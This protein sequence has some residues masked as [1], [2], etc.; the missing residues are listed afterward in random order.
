[1]FF[2]KERMVNMRQYFNNKYN[3]YVYEIFSGGY[4]AT[5]K[6]KV[7][8]TTLLGSCVSACLMDEK[9][10]VAGMN[11]FLLPG[12][13]RREDM[14]ASPSAKY[15]MH[16]MEMLIN[17]MMK[18]GARRNNLKA[19]IFGGGHI[20][21]ASN[22]AVSENNVSFIKAY[23]AMEE[24]PVLA[25]DLGGT[26]GRKILLFPDNF[27]VYLKKVK[28]EHV[29]QRDKDILSKTQKLKDK[30]GELTLFD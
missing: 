11:H 25:E 29:Y 27:S 2:I 13:L 1:M 22:G 10:G 4:Y 19:K 18:L 20:I 28:K 16:A 24:I 12:D 6:K 3:R 7:I 15:G 14:I 21:E 17:S 26:L 30:S 5:D 8:I 23:L 9:S